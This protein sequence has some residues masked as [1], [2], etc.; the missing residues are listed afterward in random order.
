[1]KFPISGCL[2]L[3]LPMSTSPYEEG[4]W[5]NGCEKRLK[6]SCLVLQFEAILGSHIEEHL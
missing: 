2:W 5:L 3:L 4:T 1:M 6:H